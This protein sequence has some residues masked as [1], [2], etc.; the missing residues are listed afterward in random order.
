M[1]I[2][3]IVRHFDVVLSRCILYLQKN[4]YLGHLDIKVLE[5]LWTKLIKIFRKNTIYILLTSKINKIQK[6]K[7]IL[8]ILLISRSP[9]LVILPYHLKKLATILNALRFKYNTNLKGRFFVHSLVKKHR[10]IY[11][12]HF[13]VENK[14]RNTLLHGMHTIMKDYM[15]NY[16]DLFWVTIFY[17]RIY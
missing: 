3:Y 6:K 11:S 13:N 8:Q 9:S 7:I 5:L 1:T 2:L 14:L 15:Q 17:T 12:H 4:A 10:K 16:N